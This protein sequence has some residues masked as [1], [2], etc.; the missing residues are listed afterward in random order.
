MYNVYPDR[1]KKSA[2]FSKQKTIKFFL[3][4]S[5]TVGTEDRP[6]EAAQ[7]ME[8]AAKLMVRVKQYDQAAEALH[9]TLQLYSQSGGTGAAGRVVLNLILV[10]VREIEEVFIP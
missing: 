4:A 9:T 8:T 2:G 7:H 1:R 5:E 6:V 3:K 10:Q